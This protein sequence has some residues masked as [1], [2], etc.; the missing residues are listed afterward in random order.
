MQRR[1]CLKAFRSG[2]LSRS[3]L[4]AEL[5]DAV[6]AVYVVERATATQHSPQGRLE[7]L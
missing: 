1:T 5:L 7:A 3:L 6:G 4:T 2:R